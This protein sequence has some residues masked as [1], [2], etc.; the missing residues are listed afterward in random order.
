LEEKK[1]F[2]GV[3][4]LL[5]GNMACGVHKN[6]LIVR[7]GMAYYDQALARP[8]THPLLILTCYPHLDITF[9]IGY[10]TIIIQISSAVAAVVRLSTALSPQH[11]L[12]F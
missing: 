7:V 2:G 12:D 8:H 4:F 1:I 6:D 11:L 10:R 3:G 5:H 9:N